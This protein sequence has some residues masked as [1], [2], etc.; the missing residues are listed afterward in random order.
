MSPQ[1][2]YKIGCCGY[3]VAKKKYY[4][5]FNCI[6][7]N[8]TFY[9]LP[10]IET[11]EKWRKEAK[12]DFEFIVKAFQVI[13]HP[14]TSLTY[15]RLKEKIK[16]KEN[17]GF[18]K[19]TDE[20]FEA[21]EKTYQICK[22]LNCNKILFQT[23]ASFKPTKENL[24]NLRKFF[25]TIKK[26]YPK[27]LNYILEVRGKDWEDKIIKEICE[28]LNLIHCVDPLNRKPVFGKFN[29]FR[30]H[31]EYKNEKIIY[32]HIYQAEEL[33]EIKNSCDKELNYVMFNNSNMFLDAIKFKDLVGI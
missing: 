8:S 11:A 10:K 16:N 24:N 22:I 1:K 9:Q 27:D 2:I 31:G 19:P 28:E 25:N 4:E 32:R 15:K 18:F 30:L 20:V 14:A 5:N 12:E 7:L 23:P 26:E 13:T 3:P 33:R 6:E 17:C 21:F 29:Y